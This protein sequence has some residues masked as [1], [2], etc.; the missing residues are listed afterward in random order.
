MTNR[1]TT[2]LFSNLLLLSILGQT[3]G[4]SSVASRPHSWFKV[5]TLR[6]GVWRISEG[7]IDNIYL[8]AGRDSAMLIDTGLGVANLRDFVTTITSLPLIVINTHA[9]LDHTGGSF[10][11]PRV[12]AHPDDFD[13]IRF[14]GKKQFRKYTV[15]S[16]PEFNLPDSLK[17][18][19][20]DSLFNVFLLPVRDGQV[21]DLGQRRIEVIHTPGHTAGSICLLDHKDGVLYSGDTNNGLSW[22]HPP[23]ALP[24]EV[25]MESLQKLLN[26]TEFHTL[27]PGHDLPFDREFISEQI[28]C[29]RRIIAGECVGVPYE[30]LAGAR[31]CGYGRARVAYDPERISAAARH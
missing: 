13:M 17:F 2:I 16:L 23:D 27:Y 5:D 31:V 24:L 28:E 6:E 30:S 20:S 12:Y 18:P 15:A 22:L 14:F 25:Y 4:Q 11:F 26:R 8:V 1:S 10:Q 9:H 19:V 21:F 3:F 7:D 29:V